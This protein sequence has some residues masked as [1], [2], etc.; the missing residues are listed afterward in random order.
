MVA[1]THPQ[2]AI[3]R[4]AAAA[5]RRQGRER[6]EL[7]SQLLFGEPVRILESNKNWSRIACAE[8]GFEAYVRNEQIKAV[9]ELTFLRQKSSPAF[10]LDLFAP[11]LGNQFA[12]PITLG[13]RLP[14]F[15]GLHLHLD[16]K[17]YTYSGQAAMSADLKTSPEL[18]IKLARKLLYVPQLSGGRTPSGI[19]SAALVQLIG[20]IVGLQLPRTAETQANC[21]R[22]VD[23]MVQC[24]A[25]DLA[26]FDD[27]RGNI[28][29]VGFILP[30]S[31]ILHA[32][33]CVRIDAIDHYGIFNFERGRYTHRLRIVKRLL[34]DMKQQDVLK[35][36]KEMEEV[37]PAQLSVFG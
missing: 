31:R 18:I 5:L 25:A 28:N 24:Q 17:R 9:D 4:F 21:G 8:D 19:D 16:D 12:L 27:N 26:F 1:N 10:A 29:H 7:V 32:G 34:P 2:Y 36:K 22:T 35:T 23:F 14:D 37:D 15:D 20:R 3:G 13:A 33:D 6:A 30:D 11:V